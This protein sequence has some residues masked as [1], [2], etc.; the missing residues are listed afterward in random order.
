MRT[1]LKLTALTSTIAFMFL[2]VGAPTSSA[3]EGPWC[4]RF[5]GS[6]DYVED[7]SMRSFDMCLNEITGTGG[8]AI[9]SPNPRYRGAAVTQPVRRKYR[10]RRR[11][12]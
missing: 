1:L 4:A 7:C 12:G 9:C 3:T 8:G 5:P 10:Q 2:L 11:H 6:N